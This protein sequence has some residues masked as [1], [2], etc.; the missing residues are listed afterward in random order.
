VVNHNYET[1]EEQVA[2]G[3]TC[4]T[5]AYYLIHRCIVTKCDAQF[6]TSLLF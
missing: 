6:R 5:I 2:L 4:V 3:R 1:T